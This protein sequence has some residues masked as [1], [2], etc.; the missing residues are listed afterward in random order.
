MT[1]TSGDLSDVN[2]ADALEQAQAADGDLDDASESLDPAVPANA[3][4]SRWDA[5]PADVIEQAQIIEPGHDD[6]YPDSD[7][8]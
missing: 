4:A 1:E 6:D 8:G 5:D 3:Q 7:E 2:E